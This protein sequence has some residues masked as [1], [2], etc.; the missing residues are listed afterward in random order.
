V[1]STRPYQPYEVTAQILKQ[2]NVA[3]DFSSDGHVRYA[4]RSL[5]GSEVYFV[6][7]RTNQ[8]CQAECLFR[9][10]QGAPELWN[11]LTGE[12]MSLGTYTRKG[13][14]TAIP[15]QFEANQSFFVVF[16]PEK[17]P[18]AASKSNLKNFP[19]KKSIAMLDGTWKLT[20]DPAFGGPGEVVFDRLEDWTQRPEEG[21]KY[22]SGSVIY[23]KN[24]KLSK[25]QLSSDSRRWIH[26]GEV[27]NLAEVTLNGQNL[28]TLWTAP[29]S[30]DISKAVK[31]GDNQLQIKVV[32]L[33]PNRLI[34]DEKIP[35]DGIANRKWPEW[36]LQKQPRK[37]ARTTFATYNFYKKDAPLLKSGLIGPVVIL[38]EGRK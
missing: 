6:S 37:S 14:I 3:E 10:A 2:L 36:L 21:I 28:G 17:Q 9:V 29:W 12:T 30:L 13:N 35:S 8:F 20:F 18:T 5:E 1:D 32:N 27:Y 26:L 22:Y 34:G 7:N 25:S 19:G 24:F 31:E 23:Q 16:N 15:L 11:P 33:W 38:T 4:H